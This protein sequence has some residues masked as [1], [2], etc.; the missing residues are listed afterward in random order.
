MYKFILNK[1]KFCKDEKDFYYTFKN[2][3]KTY[4]LAFIEVLKTIK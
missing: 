1:L 2:L 4:D 3:I